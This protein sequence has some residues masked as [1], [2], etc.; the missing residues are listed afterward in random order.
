MEKL[1]LNYSM[2]NIPTPN[3]NTYILKLIDK[4]EAVIKRMRWKLFLYYETN[5]NDNNNNEPLQENFGFKSRNTPPPQ[6]E[7]EYFENDL[8]DMISSIKFRNR[9][10]E[11]QKTLKDDI[12]KINA[13]EKA[14]IFAD[15]T[16][17]IYELSPDD[18]LKLLKD[19]ITK[20]YKKAPT[21]LKP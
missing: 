11:F 4:V 10:D 2:K 18:H 20:T 16:T 5:N 3:N 12:R 21:K 15:K 1:N 7:L 9:K 17:N 14:F 19:N 13:S 8:F 6:A